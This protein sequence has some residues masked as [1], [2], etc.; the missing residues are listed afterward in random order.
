MLTISLSLVASYWFLQFV[1]AQ[2]CR[3]SLRLWTYVTCG[4]R[5]VYGVCM[6]AHVHSWYNGYGST[7]HRKSAMHQM[8]KSRSSKQA[9]IQQA[10]NQQLV[11]YSMSYANVISKTQKRSLA[12]CV[13]RHQQQGNLGNTPS[14]SLEG[15]G[16]N[17]SKFRKKK[18]TLIT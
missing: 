8:A 1:S 14:F 9:A 7:A 13:G 16:E 18:W 3:P 5:C 2:C 12:W 4:S 17:L 11:A 10:S 15:A 6:C